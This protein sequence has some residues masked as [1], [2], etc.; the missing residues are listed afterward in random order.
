MKT[1]AAI[2]GMSTGQTIEP[3]RVALWLS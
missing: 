3:A 2:V 1:T